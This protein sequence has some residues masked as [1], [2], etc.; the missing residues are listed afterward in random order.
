ME[1]MF[2]DCSS[3]ESIDLSGIDTSGAMNMDGAFLNCSALR[4]LD[5]SVFDMME[6]GYRASDMLSGCKALCSIILPE[7]FSQLFGSYLE[8]GEWK[9]VASGETYLPHN[10][11]KELGGEYVLV[12]AEPDDPQ[13]PAPPTDPVEPDNPQPPTPPADSNNPSKPQSPTRPT[14]PVA[15]EK[16]QKPTTTPPKPSQPVAPI[17]IAHAPISYAHQTYTGKQIKPSLQVTHKG[18]ALKQGVDYTVTYKNNKAVGKAQA[19]V[20]GIG[21]YTG[22]R[23][24]TFKILPKATSVSKA[25]AAKRGFTVAWKK[26]SKANLKQTTGYKVQWS[27]D[28][29]FKKSVKSKLVKKSKTTSLKV[30]KL[31]GGKKYYVR[32]CAYKKAG[33]T[34]YY[35]SWSK[36]KAVKTKK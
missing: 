13:R 22:T 11:P 3:L 7:K 36:A 34:Y 1:Y 6:V 29:S 25:K 27:T 2:S 17:S 21:K 19:L 26:P 35:S 4:S 9:H 15:P 14:T 20:K 8:Q 30:S 23:T 18:K 12:G 28:K 33:G 32:V 5:L 31:K 10:I 16:P 24:I